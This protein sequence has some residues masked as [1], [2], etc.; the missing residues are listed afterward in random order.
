VLDFYCAAAKLC[1]EVDGGQHDVPEHRQ[2]DEERTAFL[3][4]EGIR[5][6]RFWN[7]QIRENLEGVLERIRMELRAAPHPSPLPLGEREV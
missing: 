3:R 4:R 6:V 2:H 5:T 1:V 7:S